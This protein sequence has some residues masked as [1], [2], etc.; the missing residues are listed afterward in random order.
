MVNEKLPLLKHEVIF[1]STSSVMASDILHWREK[2]SL[3]P[4]PL[5]N[6]PVFDFKLDPVSFPRKFVFQEM[7]YNAPENW[8]ETGS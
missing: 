5:R 1:A 8:K 2:G 7:G 3:V 4:V 6:V